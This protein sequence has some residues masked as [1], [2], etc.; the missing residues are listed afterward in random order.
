MLTGDGLNM[1]MIRPGLKALYE[2][3]QELLEGDTHRATD[4]SQRETFQQQAFDE[5]TLVLRDEVLCKTVDTLPSAVVAV[6]MLFAIV[7]VPVF[8]VLGGLTRWTD[9]SDDHVLLLTSAGWVSV[10]VNH[11]TESSGQHYIECTTP[12]SRSNDR[13]RS[14]IAPFFRGPLPRRDRA[15]ALVATGPPTSA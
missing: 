9:V 7:H 12:H 14:I 6:M 4:A 15:G 1:Q 5:Q 13:K 3:P 2:Q 10:L 8:L 11:S